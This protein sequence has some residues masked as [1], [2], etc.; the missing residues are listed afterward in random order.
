[1]EA[2]KQ[3]RTRPKRRVVMRQRWEQL[4]FVHWEVNPDLI[5]ATLPEGLAVDTFE[6]K[7]YLGL[8]PFFMREVR[9]AF[10]PSLPWISDFM[11]CNLRTYVVGP[12][13]PGVWFYS[14]DCNQPIAVAVARHLFQLSYYHAEMQA[15]RSEADWVDYITRR[16]YK[17]SLRHREKTSHYRYRAGSEQ[18]AR[19]VAPGS[20]EFFLIERYQLYSSNFRRNILYSGQVWHEP[21]QVIPAEV[22]VLDDHL[23][24]VA[25][26]NR[27]EQPPECMHYSAGVQVS[28]YG[29]KR[30]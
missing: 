20:L 21:Y 28:V 2:Q 4:L 29:L 16:L 19:P 27:L 18:T 5:Q 11:E 15:D 8:V 13:G 12:D 23:V 30:C 14:L 24:E 7:A 10:L 1:M 6:G 3:L 22:S 26:F 9:P 25:G 17:S